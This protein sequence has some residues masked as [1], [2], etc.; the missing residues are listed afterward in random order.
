MSQS[1]ALLVEDLVAGYSSEV[2][3]LNGVSVR[4]A[5]REIVAVV[6]PNGA[7]K[8][9]LLKAI[10]GLVKPKRGRVRLAG[11]S[12]DGLKPSAVAR[13]GVG[14]VPQRDNVFPSLTVAENLE[15][16]LAAALE[17]PLAPRLEAMYALFP[18]LAERRRQRVATMSGGERQ[19]VAMARALI[20]E[21]SVLLLD[22]PSAGLAP[23]LVDLIFEQ[24]QEIHRL[25][26]AILMV[27]QNARRALALADR[28]YVLD[29]GRNAHEGPGRDLIDDPR[30][31]EL[32][33]GAA[34]SANV[35]DAL[36]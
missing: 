19:M 7:G 29:L 18:R 6:G 27:E 25:G 31:A 3:I 10:V 35:E 21:P 4:L 17:K 14:Y 2:E 32:Y 15:M 30:V 9:T 5:E 36:R 33:L 34:P 23:A 16:G 22:E 1:G 28:G 13:L 20:P 8:S 12:L 24:V 26:V 11:R